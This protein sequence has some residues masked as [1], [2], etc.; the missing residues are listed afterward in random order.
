MSKFLENITLIF[1]ALAIAIGSCLIALKV[2][3]GAE[4]YPIHV[5]GLAEGSIQLVFAVLAGAVTFISYKL[6]GFINA[7]T[8][9]AGFEVDDKIRGY[10]EAALYSAVEW[11][12][13]KALA[14]ARDFDDPSVKSKVLADAANYALETVPDALEHFG[15]SGN[16]LEKMLEAR[17]VKAAPRP[18]QVKNMAEK[19]G[20]NIEA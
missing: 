14:E 2:A 20:V 16:R 9:K 17:L 18:D 11:A 6:V 15:I 1:G 19:Y 10:L 3:H 13:K 4:A 8:K 12:E 5:S 7:F